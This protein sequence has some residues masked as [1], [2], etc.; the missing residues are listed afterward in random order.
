MPHA[1]PADALNKV[2]VVSA[3][4]LIHWISNLAQ[5]PSPRFCG[6]LFD[7]YLRA[8]TPVTGAREQWAASLK[9]LLNAMTAK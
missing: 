1:P 5:V 7:I 6:A 2:R 3:I 9:Q 4:Q 8:D